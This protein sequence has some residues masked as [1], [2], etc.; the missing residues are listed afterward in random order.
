MAKDSG[1]Y[2]ATHGEI[3]SPLNNSVVKSLNR[4]TGG[5]L[6]V[7]HNEHP[8]ASPSGKSTINGPATEGIVKSP[9]EVKVGDNKP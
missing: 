6:P 1:V 8:L 2:G 7:R 4:S 3:S 9:S 5:S